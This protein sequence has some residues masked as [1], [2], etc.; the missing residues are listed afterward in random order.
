MRQVQRAAQAGWPRWAG[1]QGD[2]RALVREPH[3]RLAGG[4]VAGT[5]SGARL[6]A[7]TGTRAPRVYVLLTGWRLARWLLFYA[8]LVL[9]DAAVIVAVIA[10]V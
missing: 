7:M 8:A 5:E 2:R 9:L 4:S 1:A 6:V 10:S 3:C